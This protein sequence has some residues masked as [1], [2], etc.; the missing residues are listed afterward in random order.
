M[1]CSCRRRR[2]QFSFFRR[3]EGFFFISLRLTSWL[4]R[5]LSYACALRLSFRRR[6]WAACSHL[7][8]LPQQRH[9]SAPDHGRHTPLPPHKHTSSPPRECSRRVGLQPPHQLAT[10][11]RSRRRRTRESPW[12]NPRTS[13]RCSTVRGAAL[14]TH[15][16]VIETIYNLTLIPLSHLLNQQKARVKRSFSRS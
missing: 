2:P 7:P 10:P 16:N 1:F 4:R 11:T 15:S 9:P 14:H 6:R 5:A 8:P 13:R 3:S 12:Q